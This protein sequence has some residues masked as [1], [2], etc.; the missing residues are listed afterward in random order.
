MRRR[1]GIMGLNGG[2]GIPVITATATGNPLTFVT[3]MIKPLKS[4]VIPFTLIQAAGTPSPDNPLP[5]SGWTGC[6]IDATGINAFDLSKCVFTTGKMLNGV[7][8]N[9]VNNR[10]YKATIPF[11]PCKQLAGRT[12]ITNIIGTSTSSNYPSFAFY[13]DAKEG[14]CV[15]TYVRVTSSTLIIN[16]PSTAKY[17]RITATNG[18]DMST[19]YI[20]FGNRV[21]SPVPKFGTAIPIT[22]TDPSTGDPM[23]V[24]GGTLT[25]NEDGSATLVVN[26]GKV[27]L[28]NLPVVGYISN[29]VSSSARFTLP[30]AAKTG[31]SSYLCPSITSA[32]RNQTVQYN[33]YAQDRMQTWLSSHSDVNESYGLNGERLTCGTKDLINATQEEFINYVGEWEIAYQLYTPLT[34][35]FDNVGQL[36]TFVDTN[37][38]WTDTNGTNTVTYLKHQ[39]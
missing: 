29:G 18:T 9:I 20:L 5:I 36:I 24:Y 7:T 25:L 3:D 21:P 12:I 37:N 8:G 10:Y 6:E 19:R 2:A 27:T 33:G 39:S 30:K 31:D 23:T 15:G 26:W 17:M 1:R 34:Y 14:T 16:V 4:L 32:I 28:G 35:H 13:S 38:I 11:Y 22:F